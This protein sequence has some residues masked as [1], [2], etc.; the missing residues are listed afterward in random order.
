MPDISV[1]DITD[2][3]NWFLS[4]ESIQHK[5]LQKLCYYAVSWHYALLDAPLCQNDE[6][7]AWVRGPVNRKLYEK[8]KN[9]KWL[10]ISKVPDS[11]VPD[12]DAY[13][14]E[15]L[16]F[17]WESYKD[18]SGD[19]LMKLTHSE[20]PWK[21]ARGTLRPLE[22]AENPILVEDMKNYYRALFESTQN[23]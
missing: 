21:N 15:V 2:V 13:S 22:L 11:S 23:V 7:Q 1:F 5:R 4:K 17:V 3:A 6:F 8:Y 12:F 19:F 9:K 18:C 14:E 20:E 10:P 16:A